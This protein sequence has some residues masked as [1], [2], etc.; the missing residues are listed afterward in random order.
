[1]GGDL[2]VV[3]LH[4]INASEVSRAGELWS[5]YIYSPV[6][7]YVYIYIY[8]YIDI[9]CNRYETQAKPRSSN[10]LLLMSE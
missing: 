8:I 10:L 1:M 5:Q 7:I 6:Y 3:E 9:S 2:S 4:S